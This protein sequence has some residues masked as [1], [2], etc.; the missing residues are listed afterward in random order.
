[1][2]LL[3]L[4]SSC[5]LLLRQLKHTLEKYQTAPDLQQTIYYCLHQT[6]VGVLV[7]WII[8]LLFLKST[9]LQQN[10]IGWISFL[11]GL[12][13]KDWMLLQDDSYR[14]QNL[15]SNKL[16]G[17][18]WDWRV[19]ESIWSSMHSLLITYTQLLYVLMAKNPSITYWQLQDKIQILQ[20]S[21][22]QYCSHLDQQYLLSDKAISENNYICLQTWYQIQAPVLQQE[23]T[24]A[25]QQHQ[26]HQQTMFHYYRSL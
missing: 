6:L 20:Q 22:Q 11:K 17:K 2:V 13:H 9:V 25:L 5:T 4:L 3:F 16:N 26:N 10:R 24:V 8:I 18:I 23:I 1:M 19:L 7:D 21:Y 15:W 12:W 14:T